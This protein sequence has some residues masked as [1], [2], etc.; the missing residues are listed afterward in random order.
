MAGMVMQVSDW[1][2]PDLALMPLQRGLHSSLV[3][4]PD[5]ETSQEQRLHDT[6]QLHT[7]VGMVMQL[8]VHL[9]GCCSSHTSHESCWLP[10]FTWSQAGPTIHGKSMDTHILQS[11]WT[12][13]L[14]VC[15]GRGCL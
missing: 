11:A 9:S 5:E 4:R 2:V 3:A 10:G 12:K 13:P 15:L 8:P 1:T 6:F 14:E 7:E